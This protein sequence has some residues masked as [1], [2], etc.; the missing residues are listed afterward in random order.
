MSCSPTRRWERAID[1]SRTIR[2]LRKGGAAA[3]LPGSADD[4]AR[5]EIEQ[6]AARD[7]LARAASGG[8][9]VSA[10]PAQAAPG[11]PAGTTPCVAAAKAGRSPRSAPC[12]SEAAVGAR[13]PAADRRGAA[14]RDAI[15]G[16]QRPSE[17]IICNRMQSY[18]SYAISAPAADRTGAAMRDAIRG[19][20][21]QSAA[22]SA[23]A[24]DRAGAAACASATGL[25]SLEVALAASARAQ[26]G[27]L[28]RRR[29]EGSLPPDRVRSRSDLDLLSSLPPDTQ[30]RPSR[31]EHS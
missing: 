3:V 23:P 6:R 25:V 22:I 13:A 29:P 12:W 27:V 4:L 5:G 2:Q 7:S 30:S 20:Q 19:N 16:E 14:M 31:G 10:S 11:T 15:R 9:V 28:L 26:R 21:R 1:S 17:A 24:A 8:A 18:A